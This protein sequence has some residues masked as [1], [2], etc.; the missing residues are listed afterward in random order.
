MNKIMKTGIISML[1]GGMLILFSCNKNFLDKKPKGVANIESL[2]PESLL[3]GA[4]ASMSGG[5]STT[6]QNM[7]GAASVRNWA[8]DVASDDAYKGTTAGDTKEVEEMEL[9]AAPATNTWI[10]GKWF[11]GY[12]GIS[13]ANDVL[14]TLTAKK[15]QI[16][17]NASVLMEAQAKFIRAW[18]HFRL[19]EMFWQ[20]PYITDTTADPSKVK[21]D[22]LVWPEI[23]NDFQFAIDHL[24]ENYP[25]EP[26]RATKWAAMAYKA[27]VYLFEHKYA[28]AKPLLD[29]II[30]SGKFDLV[31]DFHD[32]YSPLTENNIESIFEIQSAVNNGNPNPRTGNADSW[33]TNPLNRFLPTCCGVYQPSQDLVDAFQVDADGLPL[34]GIGGP[35]YDD[36]DLKNDMGLNSN[37]EFVPADHLV[38]PRLDWTVGR[39]GIPYLDWG[40]QTGSEWVRSQVYGGPYNS[41]KQMFYKKDQAIASDASFARANSIN[42]R[43]LRFAHVLLWRAECAVE[44]NDLETA[45]I[46]VNRVRHRSADDFVM[47]RVSTYIFDG[48]T[49][50]A[51]YTQPAANYKLGEYISFPDQDYA[52]AAVR[53]E[54]RLETAMEGNRFFDLVRWGIADEVLNEYIQHESNFRPLMQGRH[55]DKIKNSHW[56][57]PQSQIDLQPGVLKQDPAY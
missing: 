50:V 4:Y 17:E 25:G 19:Q 40:I 12:D 5:L 13:R 8:W 14:K 16:D 41:K 10:Y 56:P 35:K 42:F 39:R 24:Q 9:Y 55:Y 37:Q 53:M 43:A 20:I 31:A 29:N 47:G 23:E 7:S 3:I 11:V 26:G 6:D 38:D 44:E 32:N 45:R 1:A 27:Y 15:G 22:H 28:E 36:A 34:L 48:R 2:S 49:I 18:W 52:R 51:D 57:I 54:L 33:V 21:N 30:N 46:L